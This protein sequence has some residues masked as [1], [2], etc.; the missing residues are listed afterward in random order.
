MP[1][2]ADSGSQAIA[3][4]AGSVRRPSAPLALIRFNSS[5]QLRHAIPVDGLDRWRDA[6]AGVEPIRGQSHLVAG[7]KDGGVRVLPPSRGGPRIK[8]TRDTAGLLD[9]NDTP[10]NLWIEPLDGKP[11]RQLTHFTE[12]NSTISD[13][14]WS[15][16][17]KRLAIA[18][19][20]VTR[21]SSCS[22]GSSADIA[23]R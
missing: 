12:A 20:T 14:A 7:W 2:L 9:A 18:R 5:C 3:A 23:L 1:D 19:T 17:G 21:T 11:P 16:D 8:F 4:P 15:R 22:R 10:Q 13:A 6:D